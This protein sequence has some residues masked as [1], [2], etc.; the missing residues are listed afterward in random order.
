[1]LFERPDLI[2]FHNHSHIFAM[3][4]NTYI[5]IIYSF[6]LALL[7]PLSAFRAIAD[8]E[9]AKLKIPLEIEPGKHLIRNLVEEQISCHYYGVLTSIVTS[10]ASDLGDVTLTITNT[11]TG[12]TW[13]AIYDSSIESFCILEVSGTSGV[14]EVEYITESCDIYYGNFTIK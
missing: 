7:L 4:K 8:D 13:Y 2:N 3:L 6:I 14:Y 10:F 9:N 5:R 1:M 12:E 11:S